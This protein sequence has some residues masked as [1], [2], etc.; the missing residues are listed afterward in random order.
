MPEDFQSDIKTEVASSIWTFEAKM[1]SR[2]ATPFKK[3][4]EAQGRKFAAMQDE[5]IATKKSQN[6]TKNA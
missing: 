3:Y 5:I 4:D 2:M 6:G 1:G